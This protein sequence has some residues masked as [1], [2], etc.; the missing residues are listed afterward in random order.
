MNEITDEG[1][2]L[3]ADLTNAEDLVPTW[4]AGD[5]GPNSPS[6]RLALYRL[7][8]RFLAMEA[9]MREIGHW[10]DTNQNRDID[11]QGRWSAIQSIAAPYRIVETDPLIEALEAIS[12]SINAPVF[13]EKLRAELAKRGME[14][15]EAK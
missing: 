11:F 7:C 15:G 5:F 13:A 4:C 9:D 8:T 2:R 14:L 12:V 1:Q 3:A 10:T 6:V